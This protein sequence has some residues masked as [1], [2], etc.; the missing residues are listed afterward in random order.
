MSVAQAKGDRVEKDVLALL[1]PCC[2]L[3]LSVMMLCFEMDMQA[4][5]FIVFGGAVLNIYMFLY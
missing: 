3:M 5:Y 1:T 4:E 2:F